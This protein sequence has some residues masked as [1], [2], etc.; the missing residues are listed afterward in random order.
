MTLALG[1]IALTSRM[2][3][4]A[5]IEA[6]SSDFIEAARA[7]GLPERTI[8]VKHACATRSSRCSP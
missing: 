3:R 5:M 2:T 8:V 1:M 4:S 7:K 6:L